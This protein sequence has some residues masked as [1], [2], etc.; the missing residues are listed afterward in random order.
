MS[1]GLYTIVVTQLVSHTQSD[2]NPI[3]AKVMAQHEGF[4]SV[5]VTIPKLDL[6]PGTIS[7]TENKM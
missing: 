5:M 3:I 4:K 2:K 7:V 6:K 1:S